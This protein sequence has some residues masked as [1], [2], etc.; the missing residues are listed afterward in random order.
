MTHYD[1]ETLASIAL[2][3]EDDVEL[4][5]HLDT[6]PQCRDSLETLQRTLE[7]VRGSNNEELL[8]PP[9]SV[10]RE[11]AT[12][13]TPADP[14]EPAAPNRRNSRRWVALAVAAGLAVGAIGATVVSELTES[15]TAAPVVAWSTQLATMNNQTVGAASV[16]RSSTGVNLKLDT[17]AVGQGPGYLEVWLIN[18]DQTRTVSI[19]ILSPTTTTQTFAISQKLLD[20]GYVIVDVSRE[21]FDAKPAHS[22]DTLFRGTLKA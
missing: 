2:G 12:Q 15:D 1:Q 20:Q 13:I 16:L 10:W 18:R 9:A 3:D 5:A 21:K 7:A 17:S 14:A 6:C 11:I 8:I 4:R 22:G 19:G